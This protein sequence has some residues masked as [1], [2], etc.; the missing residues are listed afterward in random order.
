M[1]SARYVKG[2]LCATNRLTATR[3][4]SSADV[5]SIGAG[6]G[7]TG[8]N[9]P[10]QIAGDCTSNRLSFYFN[11]RYYL[12]GVYDADMQHDE[13]NNI[14]SDASKAGTCS[15]VPPNVQPL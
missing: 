4:D 3:F 15:Y 6:T 7:N 5:H 11:S 13:P 10:Y 1:S 14:A 2:A 12:N 9:V 8:V